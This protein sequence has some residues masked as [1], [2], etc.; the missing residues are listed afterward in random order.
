MIFAVVTN[1]LQISPSSHSYSP[2]SI[3]AKLNKYMYK[4]YYGS[5][6]YHDACYKIHTLFDPCYFI[7]KVLL[8]NI[9]SGI[10]AGTSVYVFCFAFPVQYDLVR[11][12]IWCDYLETWASIRP[13][14]AFWML[15]FCSYFFGFSGACRMSNT[16]PFQRL[17][18]SLFS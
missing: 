17:V 16:L 4:G 6:L 1:Y 15:E 12:A 14:V 7:K 2:P 5:L 18:S 10:T 11:N 3:V 8:T 9:S 13:H